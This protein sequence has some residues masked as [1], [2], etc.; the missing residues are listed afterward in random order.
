M[1]FMIALAD[2]RVMASDAR[3]AALQVSAGALAGT[4]ELA[5]TPELDGAPVVAGV[6]TS[7]GG[8]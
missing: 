8:P 1:K 4:P 3:K 6:G 5:E 7:A 2:K